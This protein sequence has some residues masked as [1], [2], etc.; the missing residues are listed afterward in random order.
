M[1]CDP[2]SV[3]TQKDLHCG[4][5]CQT[6]ELY[7]YASGLQ[8]LSC[9]D[10]T[11]VSVHAAHSTPESGQPGCSAP[12]A[13]ILNGSIRL[14]PTQSQMYPPEPLSPSL[15]SA[16]CPPSHNVFFV[17]NLV[18][19]R[20]SQPP[21]PSS[22]NI[23]SATILAVLGPL[24]QVTMYSSQLPSQSWIPMFIRP[25]SH[26]AFIVIAL[27]IS[28]LTQPPTNSQCILSDYSRDP[29]T[30]SLTNQVTKS[31]PSPQNPINHGPSHNV[32]FV[33]TPLF[34]HPLTAMV[35]HQE[36]M[37]LGFTVRLHATNLAQSVRACSIRLEA[38]R[39]DSHHSC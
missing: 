29:P 9:E 8:S 7:L 11:V 23:F 33:T 24:H 32:F 30:H 31:L 15:D 27:T 25:P 20:P 12:P 35:Y 34:Q 37:Q 36:S 22:H 6:L 4:N 2:T 19:L 26:N 14:P 1:S 3:K 16:G 28:G 5:S 21:D 10:S 39:I 17:V 18:I 13:A 38:F